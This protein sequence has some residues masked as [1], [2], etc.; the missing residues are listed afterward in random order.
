MGHMKWRYMNIFES[1]TM[2][3][4]TPSSEERGHNFFEGMSPTYECPKSI[5]VPNL[6]K[7]Y[8]ILVRAVLFQGIVQLFPVVCRAYN[9]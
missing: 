6:F 1:Y 2:K 3:G 8:M 9:N 4:G 5:N 7:Q